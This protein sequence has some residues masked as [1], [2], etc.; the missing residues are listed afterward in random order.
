M[1]Y[2]KDIPKLMESLAGVLYSLQYN[3]K[4]KK[5]DI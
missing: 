1:L 2:N 5:V 4:R 3:D